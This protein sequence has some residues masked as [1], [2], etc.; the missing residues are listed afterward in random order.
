LSPNGKSK[1]LCPR[2]WD[3]CHFKED[4]HAPNK[5]SYYCSHPLFSRCSFPYLFYHVLKL[6]PFLPLP[7]F[8]LVHPQPCRLIKTPRRP[9]H[10]QIYLYP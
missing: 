6:L 5:L 3:A 4:F 1:L 9:L 8:T 10:V 2:K 7:F